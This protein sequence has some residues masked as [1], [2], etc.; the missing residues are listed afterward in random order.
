MKTTNSTTGMLEVSFNKKENY[1]NKEYKMSTIS[2]RLAELTKTNI[3]AFDYVEKPQIEKTTRDINPIKLANY[4]KAMLEKKLNK[5][6]E[7]KESLKWIKKTDLYLDEIDAKI[8][9]KDENAI[10]KQ[11]M[12]GYKLS[13]ECFMRLGSVSEYCGNTYE[14]IYDEFKT[15][16][17]EKKIKRGSMKAFDTKTREAKG[18]KTINVRKM[19]AYLAS[20]NET[21]D[22]VYNN[23][24]GI[25]V[26]EPKSND[27]PEKIVLETLL[28]IVLEGIGYH[29]ND[30][31]VS[32][33]QAYNENLTQ[34]TH[35]GKRDAYDLLTI[36]ASAPATSLLAKIWAIL[37]DLDYDMD[38]NQVIEWQNG[39][40]SFV[41]V[42]ETTEFYYEIQLRKDLKERMMYLL[43]EEMFY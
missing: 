17:T 30:S 8:E 32:C 37:P 1:T 7:L 42:N 43:A 31:K 40:E 27:Y 35:T 28:S 10:L 2:S 4:R 24:W 14:G 36:F 26:K 19:L 11:W 18:V 38:K 12:D 6:K 20:I 23:T 21:R 25:V 13:P 15:K 5:E 34:R 3:S 29:H 39:R 41:P 9:I 22:L 16:E 33:F